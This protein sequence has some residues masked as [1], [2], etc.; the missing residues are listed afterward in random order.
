MGDTGAVRRSTA[1]VQGDSEMSR[2]LST[3]QIGGTRWKDGPYFEETLVVRKVERSSC[4]MLKPALWIAAC[5]STC[6]AAAHQCRP[7]CPVEHVLVALESSRVGAHEGHHGG[8]EAAIVE[9]V[10]LSRRR[11]IRGSCSAPELR[12]LRCAQD[13]RLLPVRICSQALRMTTKPKPD[14]Q[15]FA[16]SRSVCRVESRR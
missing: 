10:I 11:R 7:D 2:R 9:R 6:V 5:V 14:A 15:H 3:I 13:D 1:P 12:I 16:L 4:S 8:I